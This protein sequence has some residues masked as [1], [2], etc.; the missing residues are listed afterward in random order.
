MDWKS[1]FLDYLV[2][3]RGLSPNTILS[4]TRDLEKFSLF[5]D[6]QPIEKGTKQDIFRFIKTLEKNFSVATQQRQIVVLRRFYHFLLKEGAIQKNPASHVDPPKKGVQLVR[7]LT[8]EEVEILVKTCQSPLEKALILTVY[9]SGLRASEASS[10]T[11]YD[12]K[13]GCIRIKGKGGK[14]RIVPI[15]PVA[16]EAIDLYLQQREDSNPYLFIARGKHLNR[17]QI[18]KII[19]KIALKSG[20]EKNIYTHLLRHSFATHLLQG[21]A[22]L[23]TIQELLG[24]S[25]IR[26]TNR[27]T[28][29]SKEHIKSTFD[30][31]HPK[32]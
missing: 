24:H 15:A 21:G 22:D 20:L 8:V 16:L 12:V 17:E 13:E 23:R 5:L 11:I 18:L 19:K 2:A 28:H 29:L 10:L 30:L 27:Y 3:E 31:F 32:P 26:T 6:P 7:P 14:E 25:D 9:A 1:R 4:Y